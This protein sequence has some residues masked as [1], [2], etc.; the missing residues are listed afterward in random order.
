MQVSDWS[1]RPLSPQQ[2]TY[3]ALDAHS[4][5]QVRA[6]K[7]QRGVTI[8]LATCLVSKSVVPPTECCAIGKC[9]QWR[10]VNPAILLQSGWQSFRSPQR[11]CRIIASGLQQGQQEGAVLGQHWVQRDATANC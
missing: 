3:A 4:A 9:P 5:L 1:R 8:H 6:D 2:M 10:R 7:L 11:S